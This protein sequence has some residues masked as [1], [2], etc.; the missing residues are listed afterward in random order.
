MYGRGFWLN[1]AS[2]DILNWQNA[3]RIKN[4]IVDGSESDTQRYLENSLWN[5]ETLQ[6]CNS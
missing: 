5:N 1:N 3:E 2:D 6:W 4:F